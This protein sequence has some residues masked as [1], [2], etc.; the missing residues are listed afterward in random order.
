MCA[1]A[2]RFPR[3]APARSSMCAGAPRF[4][5]A[6][7]ELPPRRPGTRAAASV[8]RLPANLSA[9]RSPRVGAPSLPAACASAPHP[10]FTAFTPPAHVFSRPFPGLPLRS[11]AHGLAPSAPGDVS[12][13][14]G[15]TPRGWLPRAGS[16]RVLGSRPLA[17]PLH[18]HPRAGTGDGVY[19]SNF[20]FYGEPSAVP[21]RFL[22]PGPPSRRACA[23]APPTRPLLR[24]RPSRFPIGSWKG[25]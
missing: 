8:R 14:P 4:P 21:N 22:V 9:P 6:G 15:P 20:S 11:P 3:G 25:A 1:G 24:P 12:A 2:P 7:R 10:G 17:A 19:F 23:P 13:G 16:T 18:L 5:R